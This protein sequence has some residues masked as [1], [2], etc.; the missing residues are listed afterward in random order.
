MPYKLLALDIDGTLVNLR[1]EVSPATTAALRRARRAGIKIVLATGR[2]YSR[3][4]PLVLPLDID[5]PL[6]TA[7]GGLIKDPSGHRTLFAA[8]FDRFALLETLRHVAARGYEAVLYADTFDQGFDFWCPRL[9]TPSP[10]LG[11]FLLH[12]AGCER[13]DPLVMSAPPEGI[14]AAFAMGTKDQMLALAGELE[15]RLP[16]DLAIH[17]LRSPRYTGF[18]CEIGVAG[19]SK[20]SGVQRL[21]ETWGITDDEICAVGDDVND[22]P[23]IQGAGL[24]VAIGN[25]LPAVKAAADRIAPPLESDGLATVVEWVLGGTNAE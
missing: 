13:V 19:V 17:V 20:W 2:R 25:A 1:D 7:S 4:L 16:D 11:E 14:F 23:M 21:A 22:I 10:E 9:D 5:A 24:G 6:I 8:R 3:T 15:R 12:N 18:M